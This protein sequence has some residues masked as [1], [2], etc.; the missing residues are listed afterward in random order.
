MNI[1]YFDDMSSIYE[2]VIGCVI[3]GVV[4]GDTTFVR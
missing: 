4:Y 3:D 2:S 1:S